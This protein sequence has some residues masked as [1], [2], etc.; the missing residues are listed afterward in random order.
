M[1][2]KC[3]D[4]GL[5]SCFQG[6][7][8]DFSLVE[9]GFCFGGVIHTLLCLELRDQ[10]RAC[11]GQVCAPPLVLPPPTPFT[12]FGC[13]RTCSWLRAQES[14]PGT[15][16]FIWSPASKASAPPVVFSLLVSPW[17]GTVVSKQRALGLQIA[18]DAVPE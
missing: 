13:L 15:W 12:L 5:H 11:T 1:V 8:G 18:L 16:D 10:A 7:N 3:L 6:A 17:I 9:V 2:R 14:L 4:L